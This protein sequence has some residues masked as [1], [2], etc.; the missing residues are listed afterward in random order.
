M[1]KCTKTLPKYFHP[2]NCIITDYT[3]PK[4]AIVPKCLAV[5]SNVH[6]TTLNKRALLRN[7]LTFAD[8]SNDGER[9]SGELHKGKG[10]ARAN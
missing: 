6:D 1:K 2:K 3:N 9:T 4:L 5:Y 8:V 10:E 7:P